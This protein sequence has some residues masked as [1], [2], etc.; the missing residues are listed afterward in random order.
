MNIHIYI[1]PCV[2]L[3]YTH[4]H[5]HVDIHAYGTCIH[6]YCIC[7]VQRADS[8]HP[9]ILLCKPWIPALHKNLRITEAV[10]GCYS[11]NAQT[12]DYRQS[13]DSRTP[14]IRGLHETNKVENSFGSVAG[15][16]VQIV[17][18]L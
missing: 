13:L 14:A 8:H 18:G 11:R 9:K 10:R 16:L 15:V 7:Y 1:H 12:M 4:V 17:L 2:C 3:Y 6:V 5:V